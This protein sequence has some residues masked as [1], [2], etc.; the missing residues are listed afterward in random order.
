MP[1]RSISCF[2]ASRRVGLPRLS[3]PSAAGQV[4][5]MIALIG[6]PKKY[7]AFSAPSRLLRRWLR[8][9]FYL[10]LP[11]FLLLF[12]RLFS[13]AGSKPS[14]DGS[15]LWFGGSK[16]WFGGSKRKEYPTNARSNAPFCLKNQHRK[17]MKSCF[18]LSVLCVR[19]AKKIFLRCVFISRQ[20]KIGV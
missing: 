5:V 1:F 4:G 6:R 7:V 10:F 8:R 3:V 18:V 12:A 13:F 11:S 2:L 20:Y 14:F 15:I 16:R 19:S 9:D 17:T